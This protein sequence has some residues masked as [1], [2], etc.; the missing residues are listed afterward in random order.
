[1]L[2]RLERLRRADSFV[3]V[4]AVRRVHVPCVRPLGGE[5]HHRT[6]VRRDVEHLLPVR[7]GYGRRVPS[8]RP[9][10]ESE[11]FL[12]KRIRLQVGRRVVCRRLVRHLPFRAVRQEADRVDVRTPHGI[13]RE[14]A[15]RREVRDG[16]SVRVGRARRLRVRGPAEERVA[17]PRVASVRQILLRPVGE[18]LLRHRV[19]RSAVRVECHRVRIRRPHRVEVERRVCRRRQVAHRLAVCVFRIAIRRRR[20]ALIRVARAAERIRRQ[21]LRGIVGERLVRHRPRAPVRIELDRVGVRLPD[22]VQVDRSV[23]RRRQV[24]HRLAVGIGLAARRTCSP[25]LIGVARARERILRQRLR[26]IVGERLVRHRARALV[27][28][29]LHRIGIRFVCR[30]QRHR[31]SR[32]LERGRGGGLARHERDIGRSTRPLLERVSRRRGVGNDRHRGVRKAVRGTR[33][34]R[35]RQL[36][37][38]PIPGV[39][40]AER[41]GF[42]I[43][44]CPDLEPNDVRHR[45][46]P[47]ICI[48]CYSR[49]PNRVRFL[50]VRIA[51]IQ[52]IALCARHRRPREA[53]AIRIRSIGRREIHHL[54]L[55]EVREVND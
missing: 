42:T 1:M 32:H 30:R 35:D 17:R 34:A 31:A 15:A 39:A 48:R 52:S 12:R 9:T 25:A 21:R 53:N 14:R 23:R 40:C 43:N 28:I 7:I 18:A 45:T 6:V 51:S 22:R 37:L 41:P 13:E 50:K 5:R 26:D 4:I 36:V 47:Q 2:D 11:T 33:A 29:E 27:G 38:H 24:A 44:D 20:P 16:C 8:R 3:R 46:F 49:D 55:A 54:V 19:A 10:H